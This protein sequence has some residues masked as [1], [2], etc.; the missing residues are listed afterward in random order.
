MPLLPEGDGETKPYRFRNAMP[1]YWD[2]AGQKVRGVPESDARRFATLVVNP[3]RDVFTAVAAGWLGDAALGQMI[4]ALDGQSD[5]MR[6]VDREFPERLDKAW[7]RFQRQTPDLKPGAEVYLLPAP[8][9]AVG[10]AVRPLK[11]RDIVVF[12]AD[13][14]A[15]TLTTKTAF[16]VLVHHELTHLYHQ[17]VNGE[18]RSMIADVYLP[19]YAAGRA[20]LYQ[21]LWLEGLA[22]YTSKLLNPSAPDKE[23]LLSEQVRADVKARWPRLGATIRD[24]LDSSRK[25]DIDHYLFDQD[26]DDETPRRA[27]YFV[28]MLVAHR[29]AREY[30][31]RE[32]CRLA[33]LK[34]RQEVERALRDLEKQ[35]IQK[36]FPGS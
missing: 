30:S 34:L 21:V 20:R 3:Y 26:S 4:R 5:A 25:A 10:G 14:I 8:R 23:V 19:P 27:G 18:M 13:E 7:R 11:S 15:T 33:G 32:L 17:Q 24:H 2:F 31:Y 29:L 9:V 35:G 12:G 22:V 36:E 1:S 6:R 16:D 28:G